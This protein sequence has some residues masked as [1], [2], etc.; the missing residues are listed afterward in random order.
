MSGDIKIE[1]YL[2]EL[3]IADINYVDGYINAKIT[4]ERVLN[5]INSLVSRIMFDYKKYLE[6]KEI[7]KK[8]C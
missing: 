8:L 4:D 2:S 5:T 6:E 3:D 1:F 7:K